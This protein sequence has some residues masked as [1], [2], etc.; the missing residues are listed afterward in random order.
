MTAQVVL[1]AVPALTVIVQRAAQVLGDVA[2]TRLI[3]DGGNWAETVAYYHT[4]P[5]RYA[6]VGALMSSVR[7]PADSGIAGEVVRRCRRYSSGTCHRIGCEPSP[8]LRER[9]LAPSARRRI[10]AACCLWLALSV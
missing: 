9:T 10:G 6:L 1:D 5:E 8:P 7:N 2:V 3:A 4:A